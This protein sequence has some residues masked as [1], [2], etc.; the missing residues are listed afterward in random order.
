[1]NPA[2]PVM[3]MRRI[4]AIPSALVFGRKCKGLRLRRPARG[5]RARRSGSLAG[6]ELR[7]LTPA[8]TARPQEPPGRRRTRGYAAWK[9]ASRIGTRRDARLR[10][11]EVREPDRDAPRPERRLERREPP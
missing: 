5:A 1:M 10:G 7:S 8:E 6:T 4:A 11:V 3:R 9:F 2:P